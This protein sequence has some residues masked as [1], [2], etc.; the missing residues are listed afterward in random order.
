MSAILNIDSKGYG[1]I[2]KSVM[3]NRTLPLIAK[4]IYAYFCAY[5]GNGTKAFPKR[6]KITKDLRINKDTYTKHLNQL[7]ADGYIV[8]ER[9]ANSN[10]YTIIQTVPHYDDKAY[11]SH[12]DQPSDMLVLEGVAS[13]GF[14]TVPKLVMLDKSLTAK[15]KG[16]YAYFASFTGAR[17]TA[18]PR[19]STIMRELNINSLSAYYKH[20]N[21]L[22]ECGYV[23][24][25]QRKTDGRFDVCIYRLNENIETS[26]TLS[27]NKIAL[28]EKVTHDKNSMTTHLN[29]NKGTANHAMSE[30]T[31]HSGK[32][33]ETSKAMS[34]K[35]MSENVIS[36]KTVYR[37]FG[38]ANI[39]N[40]TTRNSYFIKEQ[41]SYN[42]Q[43]PQPIRAQSF[44]ND[45]IKRRIDFNKLK[46]EADGWGVLLKKTLG[47]LQN[48]EDEARYYHTTNEILTE[49]VNQLVD[50]LNKSLTPEVIVAKIEYE[51]LALMFDNILARWDEIRCIKGYVA[52]SLEN[53]AI[54]KINV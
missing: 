25:E 31:T 26:D 9:T 39:N 8:K 52:A 47:V 32:L 36:E 48:P 10:L 54:N 18:F 7:V 11:N 4:A 28:S 12:K 41:E 1:K 3:R 50:I 53:L 14:G 40:I 44:S 35:P 42:Q 6:D 37:K 19:R 17:T 24:V 49:I 29:D 15:A 43:Y 45:D 22:V 27:E 30:K 2:Y 5:A 38:H 46:S 33:L 13:K 51:R 23:S 16:I 21:L 34:E 20:F